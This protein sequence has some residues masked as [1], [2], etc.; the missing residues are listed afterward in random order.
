M[1]PGYLRPRLPHPAGVVDAVEHPVFG[2]VAW[3]V[4]ALRAAAA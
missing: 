4:V 3:L 1:N 2:G